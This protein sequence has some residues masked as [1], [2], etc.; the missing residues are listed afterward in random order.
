MKKLLLFAGLLPGLSA[1]AQTAPP[2]TAPPTRLGVARRYIGA[3]T[4]PEQLADERATRLA[5]QLSLSPEQTTQVHAAELTRAQARQAKLR[6]LEAAHAHGVIPPD[7][8]DKA[9]EDQFEAQLQ[10]ICTPAQYQKYQL[11]QARFRRLSA[12]A[13]S[14][15]RAAPAPAGPR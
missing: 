3:D 12:R 4:P 14:L 7:A 9:I 5:G 11:M 2:A 8:E 1:R 6:K 15:R 13:D 10:V